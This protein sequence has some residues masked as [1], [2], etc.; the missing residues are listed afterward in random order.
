MGRWNEKYQQNLR[1]TDLVSKSLFL[2]LLFFSCVRVV[3]EDT[4]SWL[5]NKWQTPKLKY[6]S[7]K[8]MYFS[9][10]TK[11]TPL[12]RVDWGCWTCSHFNI[13]IWAFH[14][15]F[16]VFHEKK[17]H[18]HFVWDMGS[19]AMCCPKS[20]GSHWGPEQKAELGHSLH[21][22]PQRERG[23]ERKLFADTD[24]IIGDREREKTNGGQEEGQYEQCKHLYMDSHKYPFVWSFPDT[25]KP[26]PLISH[27]SP[28]LSPA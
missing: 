27:Q 28:I 13:K 25:L 5:F 2:L 18:L 23:R 26:S 12:S 21:L 15:F 24:R 11:N 17:R 16:F 6:R 22:L 14:C 9:L 7:L 20:H 19:W 4:F 3:F 10:A 1:R 8:L